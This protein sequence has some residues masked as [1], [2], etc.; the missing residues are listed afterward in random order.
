MRI[1]RGIA[2]AGLSDAQ[3]LAAHAAGEPRAFAEL[4][5]RHQDHLWQTARRT[6]YT[7]QDAED[8]LQEALLSAHRTAATFREDAAVRSWLHK[9]V[10]NACLDRIRRNRAR[11]TVPLAEGEGAEPAETRDA[12]A[13]RETALTIEDA[14]STL[15]PDQRAAIV[16][17][18]LE[19]YSVAEAAA[20]LGV[21]EGTVKSR[22]SRA[23]NKLAQ[24]LKYIRAERNQIGPRGV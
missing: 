17:V 14:L 12:M 13:E 11:P 3:L 16:V 6:S 1:N 19:G 8:A 22:C 24:Q 2:V 5:G 21:P 18:D 23:R 20:L 9:I 4:L 15:P 10:V 7:I